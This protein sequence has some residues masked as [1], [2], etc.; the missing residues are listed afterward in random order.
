MDK[1][2]NKVAVITGGSSGIGL[3]TAKEFIA[4]GAKVVIFGRNRQLLNEATQELGSM[5]YAV[6]G[7]VNNLSDL[8]KLYSKTKSKFGGIDIVFVNVGQGKLAPIAETSE[9]FFDEMI[10]VNLKGAYF[11]LQKAIAHLNPKASVIITTSWLN[12]IGFGGSSLLSASKAA[13][14]S[15]VR[16]AGAELAAQGIR[17]NAVSPGPIGTPFWGKIGLPEDV[18]Q[19][20][21]EA[22]TNQ[23]ALKRFGQ[24]EE[25]AKAVLFLACD[26]SSYITGHEIAVDGGINQI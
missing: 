15:V 11:S 3:A 9:R 23:T 1:L 7:D 19:G 22:I 5:S 18:L 17:V 26:D 25:V 21:A 14:R 24:P 2:K 20:A 12:E 13:L 8:E 10:S 6:Q 4:N 16:V